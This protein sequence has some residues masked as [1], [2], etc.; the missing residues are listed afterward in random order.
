MI[1]KV[2]IYIDTDHNRTNVW[3]ADWNDRFIKEIIETELE[4]CSGF[5]KVRGYTIEDIGKFG[6]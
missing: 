4:S 3:E 1:K 2:T 6:E 5:G